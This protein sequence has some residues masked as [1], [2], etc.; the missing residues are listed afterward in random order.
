M[1]RYL[2]WLA[3]LT[4]PA[5]VAGC[6]DGYSISDPPPELTI[7]TQLRQ[8]IGGWGAL[9]ILPVASQNAALVD[10]GRSL[11]FD[12]ILAG[13]RDVAC[14]TCHDPL[15]HV[16]DALSLPI[17]T[18]G[19]GA[20]LARTL[21]A[22]REF[23]PRNAPTLINQGLGFFYLFWDGRVNE[24]GGPGRFRTPTGVTLPG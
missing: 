7:D 18:G 6:K 4:L 16:T 1:R 23:V 3:A 12:K 9:P 2:T 20:G 10:L 13:N 15:A 17:G 5:V 21:G 11:F 24:E 14:A 8:T 22:G 19:T